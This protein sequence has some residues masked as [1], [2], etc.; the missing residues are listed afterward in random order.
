MLLALDI[1]AILLLA[2]LA[3]QDFKHR[4]ISVYFLLALAVVF[5]IEGILTAG[6][7]QWFYFSA[8]NLGFLLIQFLVLLLY[9]S[10][11]Y[12]RL[13]NIF[14]QQ[15]GWGDVAFLLQSVLPFLR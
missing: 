2:I 8:M 9:F 11:K 13:I 7:Q 1:F 5:G 4:L 14:N 15:I 3:W 10:L 6:F 12:G